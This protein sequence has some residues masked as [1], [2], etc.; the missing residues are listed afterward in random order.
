MG[1]V[2]AGLQTQDPTTS[3]QTEIQVL[4]S[5]ALS[6]SNFREK[7]Q[8]LIRRLNNFWVRSYFYALLIKTG[9]NKNE[10]VKEAYNKLF[11]VCDKS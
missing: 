5:I 6:C 8:L 10:Y 2:F 3:C 9:I 11:V 7:C 1:Q 4:C